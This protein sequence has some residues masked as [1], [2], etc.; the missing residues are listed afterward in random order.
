ML[1]HVGKLGL[2]GDARR[3]EMQRADPH[4][5]GA[6][7]TAGRGIPRSHSSC[8]ILRTLVSRRC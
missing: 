7:A 1:G 8:A 2:A 6:A 5:M 4:A 3:Y